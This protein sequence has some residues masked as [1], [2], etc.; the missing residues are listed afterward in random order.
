HD[1]EKPKVLLLETMVFLNHAKD[2]ERGGAKFLPLPVFVYLTGECPDE[3]KVS[4]RTPTGRGFTGE[5]VVWEVCKDSAP[6]ALAKV[7]SG[8]YSWG[9]MFWTSLMAGGEKEDVIRDWVRLRDEKVPEKQRADVTGIVLIFAE[10]AGR[11]LA[12][13]RVVQGVNMTE[14]A[15]ANE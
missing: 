8:E 6:E 1:D 14:S 15:F 5:P 12:W 3:G 9:A 10:L 11:R 7:E 2:V 13:N 4:V